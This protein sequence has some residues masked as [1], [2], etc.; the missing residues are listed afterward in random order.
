MIMS[1]TSTETAVRQQVTVDL[2]VARAFAIFT[3]QFDRIKPRE[4]NMLSVPIVESVFEPKVGGSVYDRGEDGSVCR[5]A[6]VLAF[7]PPT[8]FV[9]SWDITPRWQVETDP[10][11]CSEVEVRFLSEAEDRT[12]VE[13]EHRH[14]DRHGDGWE[15]ERDGI[16]GPNGWPIYLRR[17]VAAAAAPDAG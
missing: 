8:R 6:R 9:I 14:L 1:S 10:D 5:W 7:E 11:R 15:S 16:E 17:F 12:R 4:H 2:P 13:L 3:E